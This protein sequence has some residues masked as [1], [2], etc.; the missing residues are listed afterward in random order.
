M[1]DSRHVWGA[2]KTAP[3]APPV[4]WYPP[5]QQQY[6]APPAPPRPAPQ[7]AA[8]T[9]DDLQ[10]LGELLRRQAQDGSR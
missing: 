8:P 4:G 5:P 7:A 2:P 3:P 1:L 9:Q 6:P 10:Q